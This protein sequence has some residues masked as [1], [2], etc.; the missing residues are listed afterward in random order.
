MQ[1]VDARSRSRQGA[2]HLAHARLEVAEHEGRVR[3]ELR[4]RLV[5]PAAPMFW[6]R[7]KSELTDRA[8]RVVT[9]A[10]SDG[11]VLQ[12]PAHLGDGVR[13][14]GREE[15]RLP[16]LRQLA[17]DR[18]HVGREPH[19]QHPVRFVE[20]DRGDPASG[21]RAA[22]QVIE[23]TPRSPD[24]HVHAALERR[25]L[26]REGLPARDRRHHQPVEL[27]SERAQL[28]RD[29]RAQL[30]RRTDDERLNVAPLQVEALQD[31]QRERGRLPA[32]SARLPDQVLAV[33]QQR[34]ALR[35]NGRG[36]REAEL[37]ENRE[38]GRGE[39]ERV[40]VGHAR[41]VARYA[42][43]TQGRARAVPSRRVSPRSVVRDCSTALLLSNRVRRRGVAGNHERNL[44]A[45]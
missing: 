6:R 12:R 19:V 27:A 3:G 37:R 8:A 15:R 29:L 36:R 39:R 28:T 34:N 14:R 20:H 35:L 1:T 31:R 44:R 45:H 21:K 33:E 26:P 23:Q 25:R 40:E 11:V 42:R 32:A 5:E 43:L 16:L 24:Q 4:Q 7:A 9:D 38:Q 18:L 30:T 17:E 10:D 41:G 2:R 13:E 22:L